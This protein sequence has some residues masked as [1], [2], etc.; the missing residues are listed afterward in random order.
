VPDLLPFERPLGARPVGDGVVEFRVWA[1][2]AA[3]VAVRV[4]GADHELADEGL[5]VRAGRIRARHREDYLIVA[6]GRALPDP[7]SRWQPEGLR[8]PSRVLDPGELRW[9]DAGWQGVALRDAV[10]YE[11][12]VGTFTPEGTFDAVVEHLPALAQLGITVVE[13]MPVAEFPG[14]R[15]WGYD[16][17]YLWSAESS[18]GGPEGFARLVDAAHANGLAVLLDLVP[19]HVGASGAPA[20]EAFGP[21]FTDRYGTFWGRALNYDDAGSD[22][23][24]EWLIQAAEAWVTDL[25]VDGFRL[26]AIHAVYDSSARHVLAE[27]ADRVRAARPSALVISESGLNDPKVM[28]PQ[29]LGGLGHDAAWADDFHHALRTLLTGDRDGYYADFGD[30]GQLAK[31]F[32]RP[33]VHDGGFSPFRDR[34]FGAPADD[35]PPEG[36]VVFA[37]NHDQV[38][39][40]ALGDRLP[41]EVRSLAA[42]C[43]LFSPFTPLIF[44]G[45]EYGEPA[46]FQFFTDHIDEE[47]AEAT[48]TGRREEFA[49]FAGFAGEDVPDPQAVETFER[50]TL[51]R[52][53]DPDIA[54]LHRRAIALRRELPPGDADE[55]EV[56]DGEN[57]PWLRVARGPYVLV[58][59][60]AD[61]PLS[62]PVAPGTLALATSSQARVGDRVV[63]LPARSGA[64][65]RTGA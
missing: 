36:F 41:R 26:D 4:A 24:R 11:L 57:G 16:G 14:A 37:S 54:E 32:W 42:L 7:C 62:V 51:T 17:A 19:N 47:I 6:D 18:Y 34:R 52:T 23:A 48:R 59:N 40:R 33:H 65:I 46:P 5:G 28:R 61:R 35:V 31:A 21:Y 20:L 27:L 9:T 39:N 58:A 1:P 30:V 49:A 22:G 10:I 15:G 55:I 60:F 3:R 8:G 25:H 50:S 2:H 45:D 38:G 56:E 63:W 53:V 43:T 13:V 64:V 12:H 29:A 44:M